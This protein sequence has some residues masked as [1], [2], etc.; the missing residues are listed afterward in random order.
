MKKI[1]PQLK[2]RREALDEMRKHFEE[3]GL[4]KPKYEPKCNDC[5][6]ENGKHSQECPNYTEPPIPKC[7]KEDYE[8]LTHPITGERIPF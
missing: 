1:T 7:L 3:K 8:D 4:F 5:Q 2:R 6:Y